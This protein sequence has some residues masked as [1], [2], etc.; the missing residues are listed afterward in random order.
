MSYFGLFILG[1]LLIGFLSGIKRIYIDKKLSEENIIKMKEDAIEDGVPEYIAEEK[2][3]ILT[4]P[5]V[6]LAIYTLFGVITFI[7][8][9]ISTF[10]RKHT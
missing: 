1:W 7:T 5:K 2:L 4:K 6:L 10:K 9:T 8:D 3:A